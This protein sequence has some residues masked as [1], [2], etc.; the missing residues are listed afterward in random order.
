[1]IHES[2]RFPCI[3]PLVRI[4]TKGNES[5]LANLSNGKWV[6]ITNQTLD[7]LKGNDLVAIK[8]NLAELVLPEEADEFVK[9]LLENEFLQLSGGQTDFAKIAFF[10]H[11][12]YLNVTDHCN[13]SCHHC[14][15]GSHPGLGHGLSAVQLCRV[16]SSLREGGI[17]NLVLSGGEP[18]SRPGIVR[19]LEHSCS[20][21]FSEITLLTNGTIHN[22]YLVDAVVA[23]VDKVHVSVD[24][25][26]EQSN[27]VLRGRGNFDR[28]IKG[29]TRLKEAGVKNVQL[30]I[31]ITSANI[32][33]MNEMQVLCDRLGVGLNTTIFSEVG[34]GSQYAYLKPT[35][36][37]LIAYFG[38]TANSIV[39]GMDSES[40]ST[41]DI[42]AG[43]TCGAGTWMIS[44]DC[45]G[46]VYPCHLLHQP[47][48]I[49]GNLVSQP[50]LKT[51]LT[52]S[53]VINKFHHRT[54]ENRRCHGCMV[55]YF[56][57]GGCLAHTIAASGDGERSWQNRDP[58]CEVHKEV[59]SI[60][61]WP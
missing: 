53:A 32:S 33:R 55:E 16:L 61:L 54:V 30:V 60:Q 9:V 59:L 12:A 5:I 50:D 48:L 6:R 41:L 58:F 57:K 20:L 15:F 37:E 7:C 2:C 43:V 56:C 21:D 27:A 31:S 46:N 13:L 1:M 3:A 14:Y 35:T 47:D 42:S 8:E 39:C 11:T 10:P 28:A 26:D 23:N 22:N 40:N 34:R 44:V 52:Q 18:L 19:L 49:V 36:K 25:P 38:Q 24:G 4:V 17:T 45:R 29:I 51:V